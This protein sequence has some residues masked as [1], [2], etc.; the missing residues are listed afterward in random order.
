MVSRRRSAIRGWCFLM[1]LLR[2]TYA[3]RQGH[4]ALK[5]M[6]FSWILPLSKISFDDERITVN[7]V[8]VLQSFFCL[9][10]LELLAI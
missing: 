3:M 5:K 10:L 6:F 1:M 8:N 7:S 2:L 9:D 4:N